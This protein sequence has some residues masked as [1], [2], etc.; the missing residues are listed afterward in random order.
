MRRP[1]V[2]RGLRVLVVW[3][4]GNWGAKS[5][6]STLWTTVI[7]HTYLGKAKAVKMNGCG[8]LPVNDVLLDTN[9]L[10]PALLSPFQAPGRILDLVLAGKIT[11]VVDDRIL[12][13]YRTV[14]AR[15]KFGFDRRA[16]HDLFLYCELA[17]MV[18]TAAPLTTTLPDPDDRIFLEAAGAAQAP[19]VSG[20]LR[21][22]P[23]E[24]CHD[25]VVLSPSVFL[26]RWQIQEG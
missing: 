15:P 2:S 1:G 22:Y 19:L 5:R 4:Y 11:P 8:A 7:Y 21:H 14:L 10:V 16:V 6:A 23:P 18:V 25:V 3:V 26:E 13:E 17:G 9:V 12:A 24:Q 20:N